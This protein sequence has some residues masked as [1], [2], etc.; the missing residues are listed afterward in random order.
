M[1]SQIM[2]SFGYVIFFPR[3]DQVPSNCL[4]GILYQE[5][6]AYCNQLV[7][8]ITFGLDQSDHN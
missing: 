5:E 8:V 3:I 1:L 6:V 2:L 4:L 7:Y